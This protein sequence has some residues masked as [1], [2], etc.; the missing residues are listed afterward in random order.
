MPHLHMNRK[1]RRVWTLTDP[2][3]PLPSPS[4]HWLCSLLHPLPLNDNIFN[5]NPRQKPH[6]FT[7]TSQ[8]DF[9]ISEI[10]TGSCPSNFRSFWKPRPSWEP[11]SSYLSFVYTS[12]SL[13]DRDFCEQ[14]CVSPLT[15]NSQHTV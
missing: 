10:I 13:V 1:P 6:M 8:S 4:P 11:H 15:P 7:N 9:D 2:L 14:G 12:V 3:P 5:L